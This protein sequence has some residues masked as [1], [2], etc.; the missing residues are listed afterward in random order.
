MA[1]DLGLP[2]SSSRFRTLHTMTT[3]AFCAATPLAWSRSP[4]VD[5]YLKKALSTLQHELEHL[6]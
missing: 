4:S 3:L 5:L 2:K 1:T 6:E